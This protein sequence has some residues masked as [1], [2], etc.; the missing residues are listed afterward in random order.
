MTIGLILVG[1]ILGYFIHEYKIDI[2]SDQDEL[3]KNK[4]IIKTIN[5]NLQFSIDY[6]PMTKIRNFI[7]QS[8][9]DSLKKHP[10]PSVGTITVGPICYSTL[11]Y[12]DC[13][14]SELLIFNTK[15][16]KLAFRICETEL[17]DRS[18]EY[19]APRLLLQQEIYLKDILI[20]KGNYLLSSLA[21]SE[22]RDIQILNPE[23]VKQFV[24]IFDFKPE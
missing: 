11:F 9:G 19:D 14:R 13:E 3:E 5:D 17:E 4:T 22:W 10:F 12:C 23:L 21:D 2:K 16:N 6:I 18:N 20:F 1:F 15:I 24:E 8:Y 7:F